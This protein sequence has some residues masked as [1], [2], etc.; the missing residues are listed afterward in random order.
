LG[1]AAV[2]GADETA[3]SADSEKEV[4]ELLAAANTAIAEQIRAETEQ[5][6]GSVLFT[7]SN[8]MTNRFSRS[9]GR[10][11]RRSIVAIYTPRS[12][13]RC[14]AP[15]RFERDA[16][17]HPPPPAGFQELRGHDLLAGCVHA[18]DRL[19]CERQV[20]RARCAPDPPRRG[21]RLLGRRDSG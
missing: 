7:A 18:A 17:V 6:L 1:H 2:R 10:A 8:R 12:R 21:A 4:P 5:L 16:H 3:G 19:Q 20:E 11:S 9:D 14:H 13:P 15:T